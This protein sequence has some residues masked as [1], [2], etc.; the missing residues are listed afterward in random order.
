MYDTTRRGR[1]NLFRLCL[2]CNRLL[3]AVEYS[4]KRIRVCS[5]SRVTSLTDGRR[6]VRFV[7]EGNEGGRHVR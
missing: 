1:K 6:G 3:D 4:R 7:F 2:E 5:Q